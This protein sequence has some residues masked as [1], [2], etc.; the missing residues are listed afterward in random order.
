MPDFTAH[1][2]PVLAVA[3]PTCRAK[4]GAWCRRPSGHVAS[5]LHKTRRIEADRLFIE[6]HGEL[7]AIIRAA[8]GWLIDPRGRARD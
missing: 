3:C 4:A 2:H 7:A 8:P 5:D 1:E 6:Q